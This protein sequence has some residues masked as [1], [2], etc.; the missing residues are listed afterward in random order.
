MKAK[1]ET[2]LDGY[3]IGMNWILNVTS[4]KVTKTFFLGQD[5]K[6]CKRVLGM[7][8]SYIADQIGSKDLRNETTRNKIAKFI[9][10]ELG[11]NESN[12]NELEP[13]SL[14]AQ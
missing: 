4:K 10:N 5:V 13:W 3:G 11:I 7:D 8:P 1:L 2:Q 6:F 9:V 14:C 12:V